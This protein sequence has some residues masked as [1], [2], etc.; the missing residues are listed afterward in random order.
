MVFGFEAL[1]EIVSTNKFQA[2][3]ATLDCNS[4]RQLKNN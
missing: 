1:Y 2:L 3:C 4:K